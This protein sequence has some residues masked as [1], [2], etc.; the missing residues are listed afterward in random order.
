MSIQTTTTTTSLDDGSNTSINKQMV[1][2]LKLSASGSSN[3][4][5]RF[6]CYLATKSNKL[7]QYELEITPEHIQIIS[8]SKQKVKST[9]NIATIHAKETPKQPRQPSSTL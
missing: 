2:P 4:F 9:L 8:S 3:S 5:G 1:T 6:V 7:C